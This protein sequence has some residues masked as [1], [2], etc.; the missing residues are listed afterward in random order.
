[1][2]GR[3]LTSS[4]TFAI[5]RDSRDKLFNTT[6]GS[7]NE[8]SFEYAGGILGG[9]VYYNRYEAKSGWYFPLPLSTVLM[10][11]G[12]WGFIERREGGKLPV[13][14]KYRIGGIYTVH[15]YPYFSIS[16]LDP[17]TG[18]R[19]GGEKMMIFNVEHRFPLFKEQG[20][21]GVAF[22]DAGNVWTKDQDYSFSDLL[23]SV[24]IGVRWYSPIGPLRLEYGWILDRRSGDPVGNVEFAIGGT[25]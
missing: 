10:I 12:R 24:G 23:K 17:V 16:P 20:I 4:M 3:N 1:M 14:Q 7:E 25:F 21:M 18:E 9:D 15:G 5:E 19:I 11:Q 22:F 13:Y 2:E 8:V 6:K